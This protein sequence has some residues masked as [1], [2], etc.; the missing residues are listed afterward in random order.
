MSYHLKYIC[1]F[2]ALMIMVLISGA[3]TVSGQVYDLRFVE[4]SSDA[5]TLVMK[6]QISF[7]SA[8]AMGTSNLVFSYDGTKI[9][10]P[11]L[12]TRHNFDPVVDSDYGS[13]TLTAPATNT[14]SLNIE[15]LIDDAGT[16]LITD[17][18][19]DV[20]TLSF[21]KIDN[22]GTADFQWQLSST[23]QTV[24]YLD[25]NSTFLSSSGLMNETV[26]LPV[27]F[28][29]FSAIYEASHVRLDWS[30]ATELN[31]D[32]FEVHRSPDGRTWGYLG[33]IAGAG[34]TNEAQDYSFVDESVPRGASY[35]RLKQVDYDGAFEYSEIVWVASE[36]TDQLYVNIYP[37]PLFD[38][39][40][41]R[42][43]E[44]PSSALTNYRIITASGETAAQG[45]LLPDYNGELSAKISIPGH[46]SIGIYMLQVL[47]GE[48]RIV[49]K[50][51]KS[52]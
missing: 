50:L 11:V 28:T 21:T 8:T 26:V 12:D 25:D 45:A 9:G 33:E 20:A 17:E 6:V 23:E 35:Y 52:D 7:S 39:L 30:T 42:M 18:W 27:E 1:F 49:R 13:M 51:I 22:T 36:N 16:G 15:L 24:A 10:T 48:H 47:S 2:E 3:S 41:I 40:T 29:S 44:V 34:T 38:E 5:S 14:V 43:S 37:N 32:Y 4:E 31:N 19:T 46:W